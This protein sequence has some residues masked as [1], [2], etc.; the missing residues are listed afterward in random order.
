MFKP[1]THVIF[2][3]DGLLLDTE[4]L[5]ERVNSEIVQ[6]YGKNFDLEIKMAIAGR[7]TL[8]SAKI[9]VE[10]LK[11]PL[12]TEAYLVERNKLIYP[13]Y[14]TAKA[15]PGTIELIQHLSKY[16]IPQALASSSTRHHFDLKTINHQQWLKVFEVVTLGDDPE[17]Q[18]GKPAPDIFLLTAKRLNADPAQCLVFEDS[19]AGMKAAIAAGM[20]VV[21][22]PD[23]IFD[24]NLFLEAHQVLNS[25][26][27]FQPQDWNL[28]GF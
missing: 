21:V 27:D 26:L 3:V 18:K 17:L 10:T 20:S 28:P 1:I 24:P 8:D 23:P 13:L 25:L 4:S 7:T 5:N 2:D 15:L 19:L 22:I 12:T 16:Q 6:R 9:I 11:L 14:S